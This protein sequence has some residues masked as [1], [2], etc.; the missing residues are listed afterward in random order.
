MAWWL[1]NAALQHNCSTLSLFGTFSYFGGKVWNDSECILRWLDTFWIDCMQMG[2]RTSDWLVLYILLFVQH[3][4]HLP[5]LL[6]VAYEIVCA[7]CTE[8]CF[9]G[10]NNFKRFL[11]LGMSHK[12]FRSKRGE[13]P[14]VCSLS[15]DLCCM[16][17]SMC[18]TWEIKFE[19]AS[20]VG[21]FCRIKKDVSFTKDLNK[22]TMQV[23]SSLSSC[24]M[25]EV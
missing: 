15:C 2:N 20:D 11:V 13:M 9:K 17:T 7:F 23:K 6:F 24:F 22:L 14:Q 8:C 18:S 21:Y 25:N 12:W 16:D 1:R 5:M 3:I 19:K 4:G 10:L